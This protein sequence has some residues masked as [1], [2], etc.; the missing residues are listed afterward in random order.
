[1]VII[2][3]L[4]KE[5][6]R[7]VSYSTKIKEVFPIWYVLR[8][9]KG[10]EK[11]AAELLSRQYCCSDKAEIFLITFEKMRRYKGSWHCEDELLFQGYVFADVENREKLEKASHDAAVFRF[12]GSGEYSL[13]LED[14]EKRFLKDVGGEEHRIAMSKGFIRDGLTFV[15]EGPLCG[16]ECRIRK[17]DRH[18]RMARIDSPLKCFR[19]QGLWMGLEITA[20][21]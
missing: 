13:C 20:K 4:S 18:K 5:K 21:N 6:N 16:K 2:D 12:F 14:A 10:N 1:M 7:R 17:I 19:K 11:T 9:E 3:M 15:T 8:C